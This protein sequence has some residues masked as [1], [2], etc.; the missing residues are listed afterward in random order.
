MSRNAGREYEGIACLYLKAKGFDILERNVNY[1]FA[2]IDIIA[3]F[4]KTLV[5]VEVKGG[6]PDFP[7]RLRIN[8]KKLKKIEMAANRYISSKEP[9]FDSCRIDV[10]EVLSNGRINHIDGVGGW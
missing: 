4:K 2:E 1:G 5:F 8:R 10:I 9:A 3:K 7:P 6:N